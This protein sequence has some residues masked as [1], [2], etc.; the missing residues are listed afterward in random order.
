MLAYPQFDRPFLVTCDAS[1]VAIGGTVSQLDDQ[2]R[3]RPISFCSWALKGAELNY[4]ATDREAL[5]IKFTLERHRFFLL[6][7]PVQIFTDHQALRYLYEKSDLSSRQAR[8]LDSLLEFEI[9][10]INY[11]EGKSNR[12]AD[13]LSRNVPVISVITR[14]Q[15]RAQMSSSTAE[16]ATS[17]GTQDKVAITVPAADPSRD[18]KG[19]RDAWYF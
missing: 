9:V 12:V 4:S 18:L 7:Y 8:W 6:G 11:I 3:D 16:P 5:A 19:V 1:D 10:G 14:A 13:A 17:S 2:G 15:G